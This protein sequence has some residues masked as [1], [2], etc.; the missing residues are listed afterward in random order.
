MN[1][2]FFCVGTVLLTTFSMN[3]SLL[4]APAELS[5]ALQG[6]LDTRDQRTLIQGHINGLEAV[7]S[8]L[9]LSHGKTDTLAVHNGD[10]EYEYLDSEAGTVHFF[11]YARQLS[12]GSFRAFRMTP[13][14]VM[15]IPGKT[16]KL[17]GDFD[18]YKISGNAF[19]D[20]Y[21]TLAETLDANQLQMT[22][23]NEEYARL[24][25]SNQLT[26]EK[27]KALQAQFLQAAEAQQR[28]MEDYVSQHLNSPVSVYLLMMYRPEFGEKYF[29]R[30]TPEVQNGYMKELYGEVKR[31]YEDVIAKREASKLVQDGMPAPNF[32]LK[33]INGKDFSLSSL[34]GKYVVLDFWGSWCGWC[35]KGF[36]EMKKMYAQY[37]DRLEVVGIDCNDPE[38]KWKQTVEKHEL[39]WTN[40]INDP[41]GNNV[42]QL[43][44]VQGFPTKFIISPEGKIVKKVVGEDPAFYESI[45]QLMQ[46]SA[47]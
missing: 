11:S 37:K 21:N 43:Y 44:S 26:E 42:A 19:Y 3:E 14:T 25:Q 35:I 47:K 40:V 28:F 29:T 1:K 10:F 8:V 2:L 20:E 4:A 27:H 46:Q 5:S 16:V 13:I 7:D 39:Q 15:M 6:V 38:A 9:V 36:P 18:R 31:H 23:T 45:N 17:E 24:R 41:K 12:D 30:I 22:K 33:D 32:T 34:K